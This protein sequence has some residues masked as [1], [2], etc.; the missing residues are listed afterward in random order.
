MG[1]WIE[2]IPNLYGKVLGSELAPGDVVVIDN[3]PATQAGSAR[4]AG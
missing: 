2:S 3:L 4:A 1:R